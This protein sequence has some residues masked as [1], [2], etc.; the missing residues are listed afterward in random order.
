MS[1]KL[2][3]SIHAMKTD[4][5]SDARVLRV[6]RE[7]VEALKSLPDDRIRRRVMIAVAALV[8]MYDLDRFPEGP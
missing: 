8:G 1:G 7:I 5:E 4:I 3:P 2:D 6:K